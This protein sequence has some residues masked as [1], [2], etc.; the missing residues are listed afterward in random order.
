MRMVYWLMACGM[1]IGLSAGL[2]VAHAQTRAWLDRDVI[3]QNESVTLSIETHQPGSEP[4]YRPL[5]ADFILGARGRSQQIQLTQQGP[6]LQ[7]RFDIELIPRRSGLLTIPPVVIGR[8]KTIALP[9]TVIASTSNANAGHSPIWD[10]VFVQTLVDSTQPYV[11]QNVG[12]VVRLGHAVPIVNGDLNLPEPANASLQR[13]GE[14]QLHKEVINGREYTVLERRF[15]L[16]P[17]H[18][19]PLTLHGAYFKGITGRTR[20]RMT[21]SSD[22]QTLV[23]Q[24]LPHPLP[25]PWRPLHDLQLR[26]RVVPST[27]KAGEAA[28]LEIEATAIGAQGPQLNDIPV[29]ELEGEGQIFAEPISAEESFTGA[30]PELKLVRRYAIVPQHAGDV[31]VKGIQ[32]PW[33]NVQTGQTVNTSL[34]SLTLPVQAGVGQN[35]PLPNTPDR[36]DTHSAVSVTESGLK[37]RLWPVLA[38][39]FALLWLVTLVWLLITRRSAVTANKTASPRSSPSRHYHLPDLRRALEQGT[40]DEVLHMLVAMSG[41]NHLDAAL[42]RLADP[43]QRRAIEAFQRARWRGDGDLTAA[44]SQLNHALRNGPQWKITASVPVDEL[45]PLYPA[46]RTRS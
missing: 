8:H 34:P 10:E 20:N 27:L 12:I 41:T 40:V 2:N 18:S 11:Q 30:S 1:W 15:I 17:E 29:P 9:L 5:A 31:V 25:Q 28:T 45:P 24:A 3:T 35:S 26:Y 43:Q 44:R 32:M 14:D 36:H 23:V 33:W 38:A 19:G 16:V 7:S 39:L 37:R 4:D 42:A 21:A 6:S 22:N 46:A 13:V